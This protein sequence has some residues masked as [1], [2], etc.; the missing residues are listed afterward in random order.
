MARAGKGSSGRSGATG[1]PRRGLARAKL[2]PAQHPHPPTIAT[3]HHHCRVRKPF[4]PPGPGSSE[5]DRTAGPGAR[6]PIGGAA[7]TH[8]P[9][10][11]PRQQLTPIAAATPPRPP[12]T[13]ARAAA[14]IIARPGQALTAH[15]LA[16]CNLTFQPYRPPPP[17]NLYQAPATTRHLRAGPG[18]GLSPTKPATTG[19]G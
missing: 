10:P 14:T 12:P 15:W 2:L 5:S 16:P 8:H 7:A 18:P 17:T 4:W 11:S 13:P 3:R 1:G 19:P 9:P 6:G